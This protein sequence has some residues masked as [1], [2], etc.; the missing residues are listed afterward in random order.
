MT[1]GILVKHNAYRLGYVGSIYEDFEM[2]HSV[3]ITIHFRWRQTHH[4]PVKFVCE[5]AIS[6]VITFPNIRLHYDGSSS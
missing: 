3:T 2:D 6:V 4:H 1:E 5:H